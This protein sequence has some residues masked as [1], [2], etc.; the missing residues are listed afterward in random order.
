M[1]ELPKKII[2]SPYAYIKSLMY[3][4]Q[5]SNSFTSK[6][7]HRFA[8]GLF[9]GY[10]DD[11]IYVTEF[12]PIQSFKDYYILFENDFDLIFT[13]IEKLNREYY[14][15]EFPEYVIGWGRNSLY[16]G[17]E[18]TYFDK[19]NHLLFQLGIERNSFFLIFDYEELSIGNGIAA[20]KFKDNFILSAIIS[21]TEEI[22]YRFSKD[23]LIE[24]LIDLAIEIEERRKNREPLIKGIN[25]V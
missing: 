9:I 25:E 7:E 10:E 18:P 23:V 2:L 17:L 12:V 1:T 15:D 13:F 4:Q 11:E 22:N 19:K 24:D 14:D 20:Y 3:F 6:S 21:Q 5:Y 16:N 8:Y